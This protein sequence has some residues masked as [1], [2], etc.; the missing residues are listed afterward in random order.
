[1]QETQVQSL[2]QEDPLEKC[3]ATH[4]SILAWEIPWAEETGGLQST[5]SQKS[6]C[7]WAGNQVLSGFSSAS[8]FRVR[9][10]IDLLEEA[11]LCRAQAKEHSTCQ[12]HANATCSLFFPDQT[13]WSVHIHVSK[14]SGETAGVTSVCRFLA[15]TALPKS[16][17]LKDF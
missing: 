5:G 7:N 2:G 9:E 10:G 15:R 13:V 3:M 6:W 12:S 4:S 11:Q 16:D 1:M 17:I 14:A 8:S